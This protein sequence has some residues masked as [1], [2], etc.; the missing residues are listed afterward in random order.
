MTDWKSAVG[1]GWSSP[2]RVKSLT[3]CWTVYARRILGKFEPE[4]YI[5]GLGKE[6]ETHVFGWTYCIHR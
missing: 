6:V 2:D 1:P 4:L 5:F 3:S